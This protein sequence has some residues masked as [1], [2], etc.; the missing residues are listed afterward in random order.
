MKALL[1][2]AG[3]GTRL[4]PYTDSWPKCLMPINNIPLL[5]YWIYDLVNIGINNIYINTHYYEEEVEFF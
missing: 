4:K 5:E 2:N 1:L 3:T